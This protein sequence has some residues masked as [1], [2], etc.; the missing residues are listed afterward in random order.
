MI[1]QSMLPEYDHEMATTRSLLALV[2]EAKATWQPHPKSMT[3]GRLA[4]HLA[5]LPS[6]SKMTLQQ[7]EFDIAPPGGS[8]APPAVFTSTKDALATFDKEVKEGRPRTRRE[9][10]AAGA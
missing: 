10:P 5:T 9:R 6:W 3:M 7:T 4:A 8:A 2:P 1:A